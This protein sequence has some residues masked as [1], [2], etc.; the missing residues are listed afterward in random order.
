VDNHG[1][2]HFNMNGKFVLIL[3]LVGWIMFL[4][5]YFLFWTLKLNFNL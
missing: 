2:K 1:E 4:I 3:F 5:H